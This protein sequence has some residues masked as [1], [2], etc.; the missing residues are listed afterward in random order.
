MENGNTE[1]RV[2]M[3]TLSLSPTV[4]WGTIGYLLDDSELYT[5]QLR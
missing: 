4:S 3:K 2:P 1:F 5:V